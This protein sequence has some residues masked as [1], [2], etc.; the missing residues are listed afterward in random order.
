M[1]D[2]D[3]DTNG[4]VITV[5]EAYEKYKEEAIRNIEAEERRKIEEEEEKRRI[6]EDKMKEEA[7]DGKQSENPYLNQSNNK[8][9]EEKEQKF[10]T[11]ESFLDRIK[12]M[13]NGGSP[14]AKNKDKKSK[15]H[16][17]PK[18]VSSN[19]D[20]S[21]SEH[22]DIPDM[23]QLKNKS[24]S[25]KVNFKTNGDL[26]ENE[27][28]S[29]RKKSV[30]RKLKLKNKAKSKNV[31]E[32]KVEK[33]IPQQENQRLNTIAFD[34][35][36]NQKKKYEFN[37]EDTD[38]DLQFDP[39]KFDQHLKKFGSIPSQPRETIKLEPVRPGR[40]DT[41]GSPDKSPSTGLNN[42]FENPNVR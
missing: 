37:L 1:R 32:T 10:M 8:E 25:V 7:E 35:T 40:F 5:S 34:T 6:E 20:N 17:S 27:E 29:S 26:N 13:R 33:L 36:E 41:I 22:N 9:G 30:K 19:S 11:E 2:S 15:K 4:V 3:F 14:S 42:G 16:S 38:P 39:S 28:G 24:K 18:Q 23:E 21:N 31:K 12:E